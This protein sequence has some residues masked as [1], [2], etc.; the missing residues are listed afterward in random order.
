REVVRDSQ[1]VVTK[2]ALH[3]CATRLR[4]VLVPT[5]ARDIGRLFLPLSG[6]V[7]VG[8]IWFAASRSVPDLPSP[9][10]TWNESKSYLLQ[11]FDK[12]G[13]MDQGIGRLAYYSL[14][15]VSKGFLLGIALATP[16]GL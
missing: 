14:V 12:R 16:L 3:N 2:S 5:S 1:Y 15:R 11:P 9:I 10:T 7:L 13:E 4:E 6:V 8:V